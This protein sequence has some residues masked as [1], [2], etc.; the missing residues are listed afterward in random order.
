MKYKLDRGSGSVYL[1]QY[2]FVQVVKYRKNVLKGSVKNLGD[3]LK[4]IIAHEPN[5]VHKYI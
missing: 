5:I 2:H 1:L 3:K 4:K